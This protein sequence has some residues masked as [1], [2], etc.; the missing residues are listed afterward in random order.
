MSEAPGQLVLRIAARTV[1]AAMLLAFTL[2]FLALSRE[3]RE[4]FWLTGSLC[5][6]SAAPGR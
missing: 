3:D 2:Q 6:R 1:I 5:A 4:I